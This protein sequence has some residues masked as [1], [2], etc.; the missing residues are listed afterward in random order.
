MTANA[1]TEDVQ[2]AREHGMNDHI[3]K[4][5]DVEKLQKTL[6]KWCKEGGNS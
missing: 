2:K 5:I 6:I 1:F 3:A 4:P